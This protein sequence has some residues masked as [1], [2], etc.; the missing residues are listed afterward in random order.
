[1]EPNTPSEG[2]NALVSHQGVQNRMLTPT[3]LSDSSFLHQEPDG[4]S[5]YSYDPDGTT[6][7]MWGSNDDDMHAAYDAAVSEIQSSVRK[8]N[9][10]FGSPPIHLISEVRY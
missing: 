6:L 7:P 3:S 9:I 2:N 4:S 1:M 10:L 5:S 8:E